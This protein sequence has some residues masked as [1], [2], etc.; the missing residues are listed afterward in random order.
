MAIETLSRSKTQEKAL[1]CLYDV[2][3]YIDMKE[4]V[5]VIDI[6]SGIMETPYAEI[7]PYLKGVVIFAIKH[8]ASIVEEI[9]K[10]L[11]GWTFSR[12]GRIEQAVYLL[13]YSQFYGDEKVDKRVA[14]SVALDLIDTYGESKDKKLVNAVLDK[15]LDDERRK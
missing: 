11:K 8:Y 14:I 7:D 5:D 10:V 3:T 6:L 12:R 9:D 13:A 4:E 15:V 1:F 2:L